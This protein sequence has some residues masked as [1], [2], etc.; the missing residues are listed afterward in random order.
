MNQKEPKMNTAFLIIGISTSIFVGAALIIRWIENNEK[1]K[2]RDGEEREFRGFGKSEH[3]D[4]EEFGS[5]EDDGTKGEKMNNEQFQQIVKAIN[6]HTDILSDIKKSVRTI[7]TI[8]VLSIV[9]GLLLGFCTAIGF[10]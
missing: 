5:L 10:L 4:T 9:L 3:R 7:A 2:E 1:R 8:M 6:I